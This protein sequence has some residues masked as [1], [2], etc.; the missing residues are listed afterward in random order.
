MGYQRNEHD[1]CVIKKIINDK[2]YTIS[3]HVYDLK[4]WHFDPD[5]VSSVPSDIDTEYGNIAKMTS[6]WCKINEYIGMTID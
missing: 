6:T 1:W 5:I 3:W 4:M 2:Q